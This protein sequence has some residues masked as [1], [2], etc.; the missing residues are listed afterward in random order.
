[1]EASGDTWVQVLGGLTEVRLSGV[2]YKWPYSSDD[3]TNIKLM[4]VQ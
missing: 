4:T 1:M 3:K 2:I